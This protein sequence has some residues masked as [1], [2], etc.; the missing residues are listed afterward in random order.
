MCSDLQGKQKMGARES[1]RLASLL[2][3]TQLE[4]IKSVLESSCIGES[5]INRDI[6]YSAVIANGT[7][8]NME[9]Y[10]FAK[11]LTGVIKY[12]LVLGFE[13]RKGRAG[14]ICRRG[15][16]ENRDKQ[17]KNRA[18]CSIRI[19]GITYSVN[20]SVQTAVTFVT[21]VL[22]GVEAAQGDGN[23]LV[24]N[25]MFKIPD[26]SNTQ[27]ITENYLKAIK[28]QCIPSDKD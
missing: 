23:V 12:G 22:N 24:N 8:I 26:T 6:V 25:L 14:G 19:N 2:T 10:Q 16:F 5:C 7:P 27:S 18:K 20:V 15:A 13:T 11:A 17:K 4:A 3:P 21:K 9:P 28:A 1:R